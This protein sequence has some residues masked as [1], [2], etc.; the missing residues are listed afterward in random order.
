ME[1]AT[2]CDAGYSYSTKGICLQ[3]RPVTEHAIN[4]SYSHMAII[5]K[6]VIDMTQYV[7]LINATLKQLHRNMIY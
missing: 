1:G 4:L 7:K 2:N 5:E 3:T 6:C